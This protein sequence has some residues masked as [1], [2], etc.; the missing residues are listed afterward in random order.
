MA[1]KAL[2]TVTDAETARRVFVARS[3]YWADRAGYGSDTRSGLRKVGL[4]EYL[5]TQRDKYTVKLDQLLEQL[6]ET[7]EISVDR[8]YAP[9]RTSHVED[10]IYEVARKFRRSLTSDD[11]V[12]QEPSD[13]I[14]DVQAVTVAFGRSGAL[15]PTEGEEPEATWRE[16]V[17]SVLAWADDHG[18]CGVVEDAI[19]AAGFGDF[20]PARETVM[21]LTW[22]GVTIEN[23]T[24]QLKRD[25]SVDHDTFYRILHHELRSEADKIKATPSAAATPA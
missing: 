13:K 11:Y 12:K 5:E 3:L 8:G 18:L 21:D 1:K 19:I 6:G 23:V 16:L 4:G 22:R 7:V 20:I 2:E 24:V 10:V 14:V 15:P 17:K 9:E 25:G